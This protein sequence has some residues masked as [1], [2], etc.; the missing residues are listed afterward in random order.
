MSL[1]WC[2]KNPN[3]STGDQ[4]A[5]SRPEQV[6]ENMAALDVVAKLTP[7]VMAADRR[8]ARRALTDVQSARRLDREQRSAYLYRALR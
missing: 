8:G 2:L 3:V 6:V 7:D 1:A 4:P 5:A